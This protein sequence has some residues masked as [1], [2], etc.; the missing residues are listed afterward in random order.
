[1]RRKSSG[2]VRSRPLVPL[3]I[4]LLALCCQRATERVPD[5]ETHFLRACTAE[6]GDCGPDMICVCGACLLPCEEVADCADFGS[7]V[8]CTASTDRVGGLDCTEPPTGTFCDVPCGT[9]TDCSD[10]GSGYHCSAGFC[11]T[12]PHG[13]VTGNE[14]VLLGDVFIAQDHEVTIQLE[15]LAREAGTLT[16]GEHYRDYSSVTQNA[17]ALGDALLGDRYQEALAESPVSVVIMDGGGSDMLLGTCETPPTSDCPVIVDAVAAAEQL[18]AQMAQDGVG[19][20]LWFFYPDPADAVLRAK[21]DVIHPLLQAV[22]ESSAVPCYWLD[23]QPTFAGH[24]GEYMQT[25][26]VPT[27][28]GAQAAA[29][30]IWATMEQNCIAQ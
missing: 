18:L 8:Q 24:F 21:L 3:A 12:C 4:L 14:V 9:D 13:E 7:P 20:V 27:P 10:L 1:M 25:D 15:A 22:C 28:L 6:S 16:I 11:R 5:G 26:F 30:A 23:L 17:L 29:S 19:R 2:T